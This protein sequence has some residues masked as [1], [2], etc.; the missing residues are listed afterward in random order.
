[1]I[2]SE[3]LL[4]AVDD[5]Q[6][7]HPVAHHDNAANGFAF[8]LPLGNT[9]SNVRPERNC[10]QITDEHWRAVLGCYR[11]GFEVP[12]RMEIAES[13]NHVFRPAHFEQASADFV[14][15]GSNSFDN[16]R[17]RNS[18][19]AKFVGVHV[20]LVLL[21]ESA[22]GG[23]LGDSG[24]SREL[25]A[26]IP[27]LNAAQVG[28]TALMAV[29][30]ERVFIDP[31]RA[32]RIR[33]DDGMH[34]RR[35]TARD[36]L[37]VLENAR[38]RPIQIRSVLKHDEDVGVAKHGLRAHGFYVRGGEKCRDNGIRDLVFDEAGRLT[39]PRRVD[40]HFHVGNVGQRVERNVTQGPDSREHQQECSH[41]NE[42]TIL[43]API[44]PSGDHVTCLLWRSR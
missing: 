28:Q 29:V 11:N 27:I 18:V 23:Y 15:T 20:D 36:L 41:K 10:S 40:N 14:R 30:H 12:Q 24:N 44:N 19:S 22:D 34:A 4:D 6:S 3:F 26:Q 33:P 16:R 43:R 31:S 13:A 37:H 7:V 9:F 39:C 1:M 8:P 21:D 25:I 32:R 5:G 42:K 17:E 35:Q 2:S 38:T